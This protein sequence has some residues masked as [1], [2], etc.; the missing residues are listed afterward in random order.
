[1][2]FT[3][4]E[5][6]ELDKQAIELWGIEAQ[7]DQLCEECVELIVAVHHLKRGRVDGRDVSEEMADVQNCLNQ[8]KDVFPDVEKIRQEKLDRFSRLLRVSNPNPECPKNRPS[9]CETI[10]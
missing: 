8:F 3:P 10:K 2:P 1:M 6:H 4:E 7:L 5:E 9:P